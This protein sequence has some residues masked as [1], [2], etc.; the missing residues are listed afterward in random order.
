MILLKPGVAYC[1]RRFLP[2]T[3]QLAR[4][5]WVE[6]IKRNRRN[7]AI[8][9]EAGDLEDFLF[10]ASRQTLAL[11]GA[12]LRKLDGNRCFYCGASLQSADVDHF[13][14]FA[15][16]PR[17]VAHNFVLAHPTCNRSKSDSL[18]AKPHLERW[19]ERVSV[20]SGQLEEIGDRVGFTSDAQT[21]IHVAGWGYASANAAAGR[22]W[23]SA[24]NYEVVDERYLALFA[25]RGHIASWLRGESQA[26]SRG[27]GWS[28]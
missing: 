1:L 19:L 16:Y 2:L 7:Q 8:L 6:H 3:Q 20:R 24:S 13:V 9:G 4:A 26:S 22:A 18:A 27:R 17:D 14:P 10:S 28:V 5:H 11:V 12:E 15:L 21:A 25:A 23:L